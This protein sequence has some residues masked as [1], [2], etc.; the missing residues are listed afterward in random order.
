MF[1]SLLFVVEQNMTILNWK[2]HDKNPMDSATRELDVQKCYLFL[3]FRTQRCWFKFNFNFNTCGTVVSQPCFLSLMCTCPCPWT[4]YSLKVDCFQIQ[5]GNGEKLWEKLLWF[6]ILLTSHKRRFWLISQR[7][8]F[9]SP[10]F[11]LK[12][13]KMTGIYNCMCDQVTGNRPY[14]KKYGC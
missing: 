1:I 7:W 11:F 10:W 8:K 12:G 13:T 4:G 2:T 6:H 3:G 5:T 9:R 14:L